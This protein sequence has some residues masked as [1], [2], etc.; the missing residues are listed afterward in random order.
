MIKDLFETST[1]KLNGRYPDA[2]PT[3]ELDECENCSEGQE[4]DY[5]IEDVD[6][7]RVRT[8]HPETQVNG[9]KAEQGHSRDSL[10]LK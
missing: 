8:E 5:R 2:F 7:D 10:D 9:S 1:Y 3:F 4:S 6:R